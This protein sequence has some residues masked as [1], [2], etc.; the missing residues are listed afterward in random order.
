[1]QILLYMFIDDIEKCM[2]P[3][4]VYNLYHIY[5]IT[6]TLYQY[7]NKSTFNYKLR[8]KYDIRVIYNSNH[9][10][11]RSFRIQIRAMI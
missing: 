4:H 1:M 6:R 8:M 3:A 5:Y 2:S 11:R 10:L 7:T 9:Y